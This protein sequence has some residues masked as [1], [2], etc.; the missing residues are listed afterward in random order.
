MK[1]KNWCWILALCGL[2]AVTA[3][4]DDAPTSD[5]ARIL[6]GAELFVPP[7]CDPEQP[8]VTPETEPTTSLEPLRFIHPLV[9]TPGFSGNSC[10]ITVEMCPFAINTDA[11]AIVQLEEP[12]QP[13]PYSCEEPGR[14]G[15]V[16]YH[17]SLN[18]QA[19]FGEVSLPTHL[20]AIMGTDDFTFFHW[21]GPQLVQLRY[22]DGDWVVLGRTL[23][24][25]PAD[26]ERLGM[27]ADEC[28]HY[29]LPTSIQ[30]FRTEYAETQRHLTERCPSNLD[31][32]S[33]DEELA[34]AYYGRQPRCPTDT[35]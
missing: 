28:Y 4:I 3:C 21:E 22:L 30:E 27:I 25:T 31:G 29:T 20:T 19:V 9:S 1:T 24:G 34:S 7:P 5:T 11:L 8:C 32:I 2:L 10:R 17:L 16:M 6:R 26:V 18:V 14:H 13:I 15:R 23:M 35:D 33:S 12:I